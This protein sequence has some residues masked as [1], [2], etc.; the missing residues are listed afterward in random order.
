[1]VFMESPEQGR[2]LTVSLRRSLPNAL[3][4]FRIALSPCLLFCPKSARFWLI[5]V[6]A[7]TDFFDGYLARRWQAASK[8]GVLLDPLADKVFALALLVVFWSEGA[9]GLR[10]IAVLLSRDA[11]LVVFFIGAKLLRVWRYWT[12]RSF[13]CGKV[14]TA[15]QFAIFCLLAL[16]EAVPGLAYAAVAVFG[17]GSVV[18]LCFRLSR[19]KRG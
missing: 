17:L 2:G 9:L 14:V 6:G 11:S 18:E 5:S 4:C 12:V 8:L 1:M 7:I 15:L 16:G 10:E 3:S 13:V 19:Q